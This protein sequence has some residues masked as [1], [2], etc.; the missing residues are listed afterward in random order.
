MIPI[1][2]FELA[3]TSWAIRTYLPGCSGPPP[4]NFEAYVRKQQESF[5]RKGHL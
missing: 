4:T 1:L 5:L 2:P 3:T